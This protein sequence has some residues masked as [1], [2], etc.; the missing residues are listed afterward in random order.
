[1]LVL[2]G[3]AIWFSILCIAGTFAL[4]CFIL[5][6]RRGFPIAWPPSLLRGRWIA[7]FS[8]GSTALMT[9]VFRI[10]PPAD[11]GDR[12]LSGTQIGAPDASQF[13]TYPIYQARRCGDTA[14][15]R[16]AGDPSASSDNHRLSPRWVWEATD[17]IEKLALAFEPG[18]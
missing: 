13:A 18:E 1:M 5:F 16:H 15:R 3:L 17:H 6:R 7:D 4:G 14:A 9:P 2:A 11:L 12:Q 8:D 10:R